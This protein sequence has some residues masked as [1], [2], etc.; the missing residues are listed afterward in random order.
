MPQSLAKVYLHIVFGTKNRQNFILESI[1]VELQSYIVGILSKT[2]SY[3]TELYSNPDH[4]HILCTLPRTITMANL[5][6]TI[7]VSS[8]KWLKS[9]GLSQFDWQDGYAIFSVS[10]SKVDNIKQYIQNQVIHHGTV[11]FKD[12]LRDFFKQYA[13]DYDE[14]YVW[15]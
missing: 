6:A 2:G 9:N 14:R 4:I 5:V 8:S 15:D 1:R 13:V 10:A 12:E 7:K 3:T 11:S